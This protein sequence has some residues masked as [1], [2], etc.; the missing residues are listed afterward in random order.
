MRQKALFLDR[1]GVIN[2]DPG[3][4]TKSLD[5]F[6]L[7]PGALETMKA[8]YDRGYKLV[9]ITNQAGL[10]KGL[11]T[12]DDVEQIHQFLQ[13]RCVAMGFRIEECLYCP[14][15]EG[16]SGRCL[17][18]K[19]G[20][21]LIERAL[22]RYGLDPAQSLMMGD[23]PRDVEA[24]EKAGIQGLLIPVNEGPLRPEMLGL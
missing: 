17:C 7:L 4:Y 13:G 23:K 20:S 16:R 21:L 12:Q 24:A 19:P 1:D 18:R 8:W 14:H 10:D 22:H 15:H 9:V 2:H 3:D 5:E 6:H 11:Y